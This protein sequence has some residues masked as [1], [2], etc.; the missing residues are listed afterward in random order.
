M[1]IRIFIFL[2]FGGIAFGAQGQNTLYISAEV[3]SNHR[4]VLFNQSGN[5]VFPDTASYYSDWNQVV[6]I[7]KDEKF[8]I[9][10][11]ECKTQLADSISFVLPTE[12]LF[13]P[14]QKNGLWGFFNA[15]GTLLTGYLFQSVSQFNQNY[16]IVNYQNSLR[17]IDTTGN[18]TKSIPGDIEKELRE[19]GTQLFVSPEWPQQFHMPNAKLIESNG[20]YGVADNWSGRILVPVEFEEIVAHSNRKIAVRK[21][22]KYGVFDIEKQQLLLGTIYSR[23]KFIE[24]H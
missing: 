15:N 9:W 24:F 4:Y 3:D 10:D 14:A 21:N 7:Q 18:F 12:S 13:M 19:W 6:I 17:F 20:L 2:L 23:I 22:G 1:R 11:K 16:A 5:R 8:S